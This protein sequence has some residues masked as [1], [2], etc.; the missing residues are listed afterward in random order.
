MNTTHESLFEAV[1]H[2]FLQVKF[3]QF[4]VDAYYYRILILISEVR[5]QAAEQG[6]TL[7]KIQAF[8]AILNARKFLTH[9][10]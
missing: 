5:T 7:T 1:I 2:H 6:L 8:R 3:N 10:L 4:N 9:N